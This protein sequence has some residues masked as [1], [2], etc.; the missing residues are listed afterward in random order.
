MENYRGPHTQGHSTLFKRID[1]L[2]HLPQR[3]YYLF[4]L[5]LSYEEISSLQYLCGIVGRLY[6]EISKGAG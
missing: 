5:F 1:S 3:T 4:S 2:F 6:Q